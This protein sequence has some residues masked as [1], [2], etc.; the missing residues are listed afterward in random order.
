MELLNRG[1]VPCER[2]REEKRKKKRHKVKSSLC[3]ITFKSIHL[4]YQLSFH[5]SQWGQKMK[6]SYATSCTFIR[7]PSN[8]GLRVHEEAT[9][10]HPQPSSTTTSLTFFSHLMLALNRSSFFSHFCPLLS[11]AH[12]VQYFGR[13]H[14]TSILPSA[15]SL[16]TFPPQTWPPPSGHGPTPAPSTPPAGPDQCTRWRGKPP[17]R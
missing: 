12:N 9:K 4:Y 7:I 15:I 6:E 5:S 17:E 16:L 2:N 10:P 3:I 8:L 13:Q 11:Y 14:A 1:L